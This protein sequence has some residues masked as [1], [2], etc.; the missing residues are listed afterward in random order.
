MEWHRHTKFNTELRVHSK[1]CV[2]ISCF[3]ILMF[4][5]LSIL[6]TTRQ[7]STPP[8]AYFVGYSLGVPMLCKDQYIVMAS[9]CRSYLIWNNSV[10]G[11]SLPLAVFPGYHL[12][13]MYT[14]KLEPVT[15]FIRLMSLLYNRTWPYF[16]A[17]LMKVHSMIDSRRW[18]RDKMVTIL[19][20]WVIK[21]WLKFIRNVFPMA[22]V[23][24]SQH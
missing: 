18:G 11:L 24:M 7:S 5:Y 15:L 8:G 16:A 3:V 22:H 20:F 13:D 10:T 1:D 23:T 17:I 19:Q 2:I 14:S 12:K 6:K 21:F 9:V 4:I